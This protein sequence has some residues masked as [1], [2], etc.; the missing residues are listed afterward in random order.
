ML[1]SFASCL[2]GG[3]KLLNRSL[4]LEI[5][6]VKCKLR[7]IELGEFIKRMKIEEEM[8]GIFILGTLN[9]CV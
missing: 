9:R 4:K 1:C 7:R 6:K 2:K 8:R 5:N 3:I